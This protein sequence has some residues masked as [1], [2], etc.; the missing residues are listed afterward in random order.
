MEIRQ[1]HAFAL[2]YWLADDEE[3]FVAEDDGAI[4]GTYFEWRTDVQQSMGTSV[5]FSPEDRWSG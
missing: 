5:I 3:T 4:V 2:A 1:T